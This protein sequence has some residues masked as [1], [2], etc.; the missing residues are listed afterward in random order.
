[1]TTLDVPEQLGL[2]EVDVQQIAEV[3]DT[4][5]QAALDAMR[6]GF[7]PVQRPQFPLP[8]MQPTDLLN[9]N[10]QQFTTLQAQMEQ[11]QSYAQ[12]RVA[13]L[14]AMIL[15]CN[16]QMDLIDVDTQDAIRQYLKDAKL[17]KPPEAT[18]KEAVKRNPIWRA[19]LLKHQ[20]CTQ[21]RSF[22]EI[23]YKNAARTKALLVSSVQK[24]KADQGQS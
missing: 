5:D 12:Q 6:A 11:W 24:Q 17:K 2:G 3:F 4:V 10:T 9:L 18:I 15:Q 7:T 23:T 1:M 13:E 19:L 21:E 8:Q 20:Q 14:D 16:T 22:V